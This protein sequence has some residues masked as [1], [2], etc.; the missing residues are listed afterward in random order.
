MLRSTQLFLR[1][2][3]A[4]AL[5]TTRKRPIFPDILLQDVEAR[6]KEAA[7]LPMGTE[8]STDGVENLIV[9]CVEVDEMIKYRP[10]LSECLTNRMRVVAPKLTMLLGEFVVAHLA[11]H[12]R[13]V[14]VM[15]VH[16]FTVDSEK[17][18]IY[19]P[20]IPFLA[21]KCQPVFG[22][23][24]WEVIGL[25]FGARGMIPKFVVD[26]WG[27]FD[28]PMDSLVDISQGVLADSVHILN[29]HINCGPLVA[30]GH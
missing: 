10:Q 6:V 14:T 24:D 4:C 27:R 17:K 16:K 25:L 29:M 12:A 22:S 5:E 2:C 19:E 23:L 15:D 20:C 8:M 13:S 11:S 26:F 9:L 21:G 3:S 7:E 30:D 1:L 18:S 28:L